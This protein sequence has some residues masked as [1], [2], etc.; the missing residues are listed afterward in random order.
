[1]S[2]LQARIEELQAQLDVTGAELFKERAK[3]NAY[4]AIVA[5]SQDI[6]SMVIQAEENAT[7]WDECEKAF[8]REALERSEQRLTELLGVAWPFD[9]EAACEW[10]RAPAAGDWKTGCGNS[11]PLPEGKTP[12]DSEITFCFC[13]GRLV[14]ENAPV[15]ARKIRSP[16]RGKGEVARG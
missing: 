9:A 7:R 6:R 4:I 13:C 1:M 10:T 14:A 16:R 2:E 8:Y 11:W 15:R 12:L 3:A 5:V